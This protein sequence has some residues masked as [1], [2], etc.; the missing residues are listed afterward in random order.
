MPAFADKFSSAIQCVWFGSCYDIIFFPKAQLASFTDIGVRVGLFEDRP[1]DG[2]ADITVF[3]RPDIF[4]ESGFFPLVFKLE[5]RLMVVP[6]GFKF[7]VA[8]SYIH[9]SVIVG[10]H[11]CLVYNAFGET[12]SWQRAFVWVSAVADVR[13][14][15]LCSPE[16]RFVVGVDNFPHIV[17]ATVAHFHGVAVENFMEQ[18]A[19]WEVC[20]K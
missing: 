10:S 14:V 17:H 7:G 11:R 2:V 9:F 6:S 5:R 4:A 19:F 18:A 3:E 12:H 20:V 1:L 15:L 8:G 13:L 16:D